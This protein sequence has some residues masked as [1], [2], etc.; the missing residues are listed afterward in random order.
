VLGLENLP[1]WIPFTISISAMIFVA[2]IVQL[3]VVPWQRRKLSPLDDNENVA[4]SNQAPP[5][6]EM[7]NK[8]SN[9]N[10]TIAA[11]NSTINVST[12]SL[13]APV[14]KQ[15][16][17]TR[18]D[19]NVNRLFHFLQTLTAVFTSFAHGGNDVSNAV[20]PLIGIY[21]IY[22]TGS[23]KQQAES[24][25]V[26]LLFGGIGMVIGL[27]ALGRRVNDTIGKNITKITPTK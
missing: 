16:D 1:T 13:S 18:N 5:T 26:L 12:V 19:E 4:T 21:L 7:K 22:T 17:A 3:V 11:S 25:I 6:S 9:S 23:V 24:P 15:R 2:I 20:G 27:W 8:F 10:G 14:V